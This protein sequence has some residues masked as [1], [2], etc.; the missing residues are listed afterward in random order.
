MKRKKAKDDESESM[1][2][3]GTAVRIYLT[4]HHDTGPYGSSQ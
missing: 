4:Y 1:S 2:G 3:Q